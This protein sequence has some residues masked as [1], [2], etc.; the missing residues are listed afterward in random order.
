[1]NTSR[2]YT[3]YKNEVAP[4]LKESFGYKNV[5]AIPKLEKV[6]LNVGIGKLSRDKDT[7]GIQRVEADLVKI[8]GQKPSMRKAKKSISGFKLRE[9][10]LVGM[11]ITLRG[12]RMYDFIDRLI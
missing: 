11:S 12:N 8:A 6:V 5:M 4:T 1:M 9:G 10:M 2:I 7:K 3:Q